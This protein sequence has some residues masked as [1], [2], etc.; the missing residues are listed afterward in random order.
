[1]TIASIV[2]TENPVS[3]WE[4][5][6]MNIPRD[7]FIA[8]KSTNRDMGGF[9]QASFEWIPDG[10]LEAMAFLNAGL[11]RD[12]KMINE[13]GGISWEGFVNSITMDT[14]TAKVSNSL[15]D[16]ANSVWTRYTP[17]GGGAVT[18]GT[19]FQNTVSQAR[20]GVKERPISGGEID[21]AVADQLAENFLDL[22]FWP[23]P[24]L[25]SVN[26]A[27]QLLVT[28]KVSISCHGYF[29]TLEWRT[30]NQVAVPG[31]INASDLVEDII[32]ASG[33]FVNTTTYD[34]NST[35]V[36]QEL[37]AD[38]KAGDQVSSIADLGDGLGNVWIVGIEEDRHFYYKQAAPAVV[39][40]TG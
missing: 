38:R 37:D 4:Q 7:R 36:T 2:I 11:G 40:P 12:V 31:E 24:T 23:T 9:Y 35:Q 16:M 30:Y 28:P 5:F 34:A 20:F 10:R 22:M 21:S 26:L 15:N 27:G 8:E 25:Q 33:D 39:V 19:V 17:V 1:V 13:Y 3:A 18:R 32:V 29:R 14:G 6:I